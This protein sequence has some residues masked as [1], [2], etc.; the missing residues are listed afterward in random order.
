MYVC[1]CVCVCVC[2]FVCVCVCV[3][4]PHNC[5]LIPVCPCNRFVIGW[6]LSTFEHMDALWM[7]VRKFR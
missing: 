1:V 6:S 2:L 3:C 4:M 7:N 5:I